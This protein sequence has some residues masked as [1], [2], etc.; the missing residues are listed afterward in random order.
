MQYI[1]RIQNDILYVNIVNI[2][3]IIIIINIIFIIILV[4]FISIIIIIIIIFIISI[5]IIIIIIIKINIIVFIIFIIT[6]III[7]ITIINIDVRRGII[8]PRRTIHCL[9]PEPTWAKNCFCGRGTRGSPGGKGTGFRHDGE[10][11][12]VIRPAPYCR[13]TRII[14]QPNPLPSPR[15]RGIGEEDREE[16]VRKGLTEDQEAAPAARAFFFLL[17]REATSPLRVSA[18]IASST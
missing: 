9:C 6:I 15:D 4:I 10:I 13:R 17:Y 2:I 14:C 18:S 3:I 1:I 7:I 12:A 5:I 8:H 11:P 16:P